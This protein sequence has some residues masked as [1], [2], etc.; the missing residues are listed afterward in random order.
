MVPLLSVLNGFPKIKILGIFFSNGLVSVESDN[1]RSKL[2]KVETKLNLWKQRELSF[3][4]RALIV[5]M[6]GA[7]RFWHS[8]KILLPP[9]WVCDRYHKIV[10]PFIW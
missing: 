9:R 3:V 1:W 6:L 5:N 7:S 10:R 8:T 4:G 2:D